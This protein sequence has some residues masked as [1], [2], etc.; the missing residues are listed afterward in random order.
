M[1]SCEGPFIAS[2]ELNVPTSRR[3]FIQ[4]ATTAGA[5]AIA[6]SM[7]NAALAADAPAVKPIVISSGNG[8]AAVTKAMELMR[9][10]SDALDAVIA[11]V[12]LVEDD[13]NDT[14]VGYGGLPN[15]D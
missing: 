2:G 6:A 9:A 11:G 12:N 4:S 13:P 3:E 7:L 10:N 5:G 8:V 15:E 14:S 1:L